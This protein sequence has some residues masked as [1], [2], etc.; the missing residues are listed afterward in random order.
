[1]I[2]VIIADDHAIVR[3]GLRQTLSEQPDMVV[4]NETAGAQE[5]LSLV[6]KQPCDVVVLDITMPGR[7]GLDVLKDL[8]QERPR[9]PVLVLSIHPEEQYAV[10]TLKAGAAGYLTKDSAPEELVKAIRKIRAGGKYVSATLAE[11]LASDLIPGGKRPG[12]EALSDREH[13]V[14]CLMA[15]GRS[16]TEVGKALHLSAKTISTYRTRLLEKLGLRSTAELIHYAIRHRL[17]E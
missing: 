15:K 14:L 4:V 3:R 16:V 13:Q 17:V 8:R 5:L 11:K 6:Q 2:R 10:R 7:S 12:H 1:M 9:L